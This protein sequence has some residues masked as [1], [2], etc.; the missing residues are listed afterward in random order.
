MHSPTGSGKSSF[1]LIDT[2]LLLRTIHLEPDMTV[3]DLGCGAGNYTMAI[4]KH[5]TPP[6]R[7]IAID[8][9]REGIASLRQAA[10]SIESV[11]IETH[12]ADIRRQLPISDTTVDLCLMATVLHD[13]IHDNSEDISFLEEIGRV[14]TSNGILA[15]AEFKKQDGPPGP[16]KAIRMR[17]EEVSALLL[18]AG[19]IRFSKVVE[20]GPQIYFAQFKKFG[21]F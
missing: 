15:I 3:L 7:I 9:W 17:L 5:K 11:T 10:A 12:V 19:F 14:L 8:L 4:A 16:P 13:L 21:Q 18:R 2:D 1:D 20:L 6:G